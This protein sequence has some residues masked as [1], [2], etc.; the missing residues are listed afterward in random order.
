MRV[1]GGQFMAF[2]RRHAGRGMHRITEYSKQK[3]GL[4]EVARD[5]AAE[6][7]AAPALSR[8][9]LR[10]VAARLA[11][12]LQAWFGSRGIRSAAT[13]SSI[14]S[15]AVWVQLFNFVDTDGSGRLTFV[16]FEA[17]VND[18][19]RAK[20]RVT[21]HELKALW[22]VVDADR[23]GQATAAEFGTEIYRLQLEA[24]PR[25]PETELERIVTTL[26]GASEKWHRSGGNWYKVL[27][28][29]DE[30]GS[31][32]LDFEELGKV[33]RK[34]FPGL[35]LGPNDLKE[36]DLRGLWRA[37]D[38]DRSGLVTIK[39]FMVFMRHHGNAHSI[40]KLTNYSQLK[41]GLVGIQQEEGP[42]PPRTVME[43]LGTR[44]LLEHALSIYLAKRGICCRP[45][46]SWG[47]IFEEA[48]DRSGR[49]RLLEF[50]NLLR[51]RLW[52]QPSS[53]SSLQESLTTTLATTMT[54]V[55]NNNN[56][57]DS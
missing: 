24:W 50:E 3:R 40:H 23:S 22:R 1:P 14:S 34:G 20:Q 51:K 56:N 42:L 45:K 57:N 30:D 27:T 38:E 25:L 4:V 49:M 55:S 43:L 32:E 48:T 21:D 18:V 29:C 31:G 8:A 6:V 17:A 53:R 9:A 5:V 47:K 44:R 12:L 35:S 16:E 54:V 2:M 46:E 39:E 26:N 7:A 28:V 19:L 15:P 52:R 13:A 41:R 36:E 33:V 10:A 11:S 37:M